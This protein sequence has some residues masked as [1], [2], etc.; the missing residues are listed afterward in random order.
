MDDS[1]KKRLLNYQKQAGIKTRDGA[2]E[3]ILHDVPEW[4]A[5]IKALE[6]PYQRAE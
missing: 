2:V 5:E 3:Q 1:A 4:Q 6:E